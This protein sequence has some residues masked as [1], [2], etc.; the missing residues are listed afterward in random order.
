MFLSFSSFNKNRDQSLQDYGSDE[1]LMDFK[2][3][4]KGLLLLT[5]LKLIM[6]EDDKF[7]LCILESS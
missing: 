3:I 4:R 2:V 1:H 6:I 7:I 5:F